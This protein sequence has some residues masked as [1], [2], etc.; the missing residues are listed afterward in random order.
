MNKAYKAIPALIGL[1]LLMTLIPALETEAA[2]PIV[3]KL[4]STAPKGHYLAN[5]IDVFAEETKKESNGELEIKHFYSSAL[6]GER[7]TLE[8]LQMGTIEMSTASDGIMGA[9]VP[10]WKILSMPFLIQDVN[11]YVA[12]QQTD[13][14]K[15]LLASAENYGLK[16]LSSTI[17]AFRYPT[18]NVRPITAPESFK[19]IKMRTQENPVQIEMMKALGASATPVPWPELYTA[20]QTGLVEGQMNEYGAIHLRKFWEVQKYVT[21]MPTLPCTTQI[22]ISKR[23]WDRLSPEHRKILEEG[24]NRLSQTMARK[25]EAQENEY[26]Q[27]IIATGQIE[28]NV[29]DKAQY[30]RFVEV[31]RPVYEYVLNTS[32][33][34]KPYYE[35]LVTKAGR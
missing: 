1:I 26:K 29:L 21:E 4:N 24:N 19:G 16:V 12:L 2:K 9:F 25:A 22:L 35:F 10:D 17:I 28:L 3:L 5:A 6:G 15:K 31:L 13:L 20:L 11:Q 34:V 27:D 7:E 32:P 30:P 18:N 23:V 14:G 8:A 33:Q